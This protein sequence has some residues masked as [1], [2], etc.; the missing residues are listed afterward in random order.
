MGRVLIIGWDGATFDLIE[1]WVAQGKLPNIAAVLENGAHGE[2]RSTLPPMT[3][4]AWS[5]FMTGKNPAKHGIYDFTRQR[6]GMYD[7]EFVNGGQRKAP[8]FW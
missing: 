7:L 2:L 6:P 3:F 5:S 4:P 8:S 1:P